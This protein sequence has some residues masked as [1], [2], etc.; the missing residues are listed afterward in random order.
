MNTEHNKSEQHAGCFRISLFFMC[1]IWHTSFLPPSTELFMSFYEVTLEGIAEKLPL[2]MTVL[3][4]C[5]I[6]CS[7][8]HNVCDYRS[9]MVYNKQQS[10]NFYLSASQI[11]F[12]N[13]NS[14]VCR[15]S[16]TQNFT[17]K[18]KKKVYCLKCKPASALTSAKKEKEKIMQAF[19]FYDKV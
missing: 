5:I 13:V 10:E 9:K 15:I 7:K 17:K 18:K 1:F 19:H 3:F 6:E 11:F 4:R 16:F 12:C 14:T 8:D 2:P